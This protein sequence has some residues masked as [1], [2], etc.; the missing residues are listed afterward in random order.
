VALLEEPLI[1]LRGCRRVVLDVRVVEGLGLR[2]E[3]WEVALRLQ[4]E[5][6]DPDLGEQVYEFLGL[7]EIDALGDLLLP[8]LQAL[9]LQD[10]VAEFADLVLDGLEL[11]GGRGGGVLGEEGVEGRIFFC[12]GL[13]DG[14]LLKVYCGSKAYYRPGTG[15]SKAWA[16]RRPRLGAGAF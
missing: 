7:D 10:E 12:C 9:L 14:C 6:V 3:S 15:R 8:R 4:A 2:V 16:R 1:S 13:G 5:G 11:V